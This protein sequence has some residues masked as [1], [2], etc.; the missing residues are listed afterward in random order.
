MR[1]SGPPRPIWRSSRLARYTEPDQTWL[2]YQ[3]EDLASM[4]FIVGIGALALRGL[5]SLLWL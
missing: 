2:V 5:W 1:T 3:L 4:T